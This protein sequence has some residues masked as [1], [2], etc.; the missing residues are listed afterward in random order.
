M[1]TVNRM[2]DSISGSINAEQFGIP[3]EEKKYA[4]MIELQVKADNAETV[5]G[6][7][8]IVEEFTKLVEDVDYNATIQ[9]DCKDI[10]FNQAKGTYHLKVKNEISSVAMPQEL[11]DKIL[12][13]IDKGLDFEPLI[14]LWIRWLRNPILK[15]KD[16]IN[17]SND[18][19]QRMFQY[20]NADYVNYD[21]VAKL[22]D[23][24]GVSEEVAKERATVKQ[25]GITVEGLIKT[26]KVSSEIEKKFALD[27]D[28]NKIEI[29]RIEKTK[30]IDEDTGLVTYEVAEHINE[31]RLFEPVMKGQSGDAFFCGDQEGHFIRVGERHFLS[32]WDKVDTDDYH[33]CVKGLHCGGLDYIRGYQGGKSETHNTLVD[34]MHIGAIPAPDGGA[35]RVKEYFTLDAFTGVNGSIYHSSTYAANTDSQWEEMKKKVIEEFG[36]LTDD[37]EDGLT[38]MSDL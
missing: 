14:K 7:K 29:D 25:V 23:K 35:I 12:A 18:F 38:E 26:Y 28:G 34:P 6:L 5:A 17:P 15:M 2:G 21:L 8:E 11:V 10:Y 4:A 33:S 31:D 19:S 36:K 27:K 32:D 37:I 13:S 30:V 16:K 24:D 22:M 1:I 9:S 20:I 3:F